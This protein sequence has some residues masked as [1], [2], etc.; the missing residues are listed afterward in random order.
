MAS[1]VNV[2]VGEYRLTD[3]LGA[4]G[5]GEVYRAVH[6]RIG[7][8]VAVKVLSSVGDSTAVQ[9]FLNEARIQGR[10]THPGIATLHDFTEYG[11]RPC[12]IMEY[13]D[14]QTLAEL[15]E[16]RGRL[17]FGEAAAI[18]RSVAEALAYIHAQGIVHRDLK[19]TNVKITTAGQVKLLDFGIARSSSSRR[20]TATGA[21]VGTLQYLAPEQIEGRDADLRTDIWAMGVL[22]YELLTGRLPFEGTSTAELLGRVLRGDFVP[23]SRLVSG[24]PPHAERVVARCLK[25]DPASRFQTAEELRSALGAAWAPGLSRRALA[26]VAAGAL[27]LLVLLLVLFYGTGDWSSAPAGGVKTITVDVVGGTAEVYRD[28]GRV[29]RTP[30][31]IKAREGEHISLLLKRAGYI[32]VPV[33]L[34]ASDRS[35]Y[36]FTMEAARE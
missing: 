9:R 2:T 5:M 12:I 14:G 7:R 23:P 35:H 31:R 13:V 1:L 27:L 33:E 3:F 24:L 11:G 30:F 32:D 21:V 10:L 26:L 22:L 17:P 15:V 25:K 19:S 8:V 6:T 4:G 34:D 28:G 20:L 16:R 29:G 36:S 18:V